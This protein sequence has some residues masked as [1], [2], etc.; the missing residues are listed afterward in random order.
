MLALSLCTS[1]V[2]AACANTQLPQ[3]GE[4]GSPTPPPTAVAATTSPTTPDASPSATPF[5]TPIPV[6]TLTTAELKALLDG[7]DKPIVYD[8]R[9]PD[10]YDAA[11]IPGAVSLPLDERSTRQFPRCRTIACLCSTATAAPEGS[12]HTAARVLL[13]KGFTNVKVLEGGLPGWEEAGYPVV[14]AT[15]TIAQPTATP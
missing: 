5:P 3:R 14:R 11:H 9:T 2:L 1:L 10:E 12:V 15:P 4:V 8:A 13:A 6:P 7:N